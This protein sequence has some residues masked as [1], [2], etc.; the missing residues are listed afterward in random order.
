MKPLVSP[1][2]LLLDVLMLLIL[3]MIMERSPNIKI[4][5]PDEAISDVVV[6]ASDNGDVKHFYDSHKMA[7]LPIKEYRNKRDSF[8]IGNIACNTQMCKD[9]PLPL[10]GKKVIYLRGGLQQELASLMAD[11]CLTFPK[12][13]TNVIYHVDNEGRIDRERLLNDFPLFK[14]I[15]ASS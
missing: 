15:I 1:V 5:L 9:I 13:C 11:S 12:Q 7:W 14:N 2:I 6:V 10:E 8:L 3:A 4:V